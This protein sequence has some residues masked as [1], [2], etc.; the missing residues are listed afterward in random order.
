MTYSDAGTWGSKDG[1]GLLS[2]AA[3]TDEA[4]NSNTRT[5]AEI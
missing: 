1:E 5:D 4:M 3:L 2:R